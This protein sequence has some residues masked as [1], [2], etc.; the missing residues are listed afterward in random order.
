[1]SRRDNETSRPY[2]SLGYLRGL[3]DYL[4]SRN[5]P[6]EPV[7][8]AMNLSSEAQL[9][10]PNTRVDHA[11]LDTIFEAAERL[12]GDANVGLH[13]G[14][15][16]N[17]LHFG[18]LGQLAVTCRNMRELLKL[19]T[20]Y[21]RLIT[22][23]A[24]MFYEVSPDK[25]VG[26]MMYQ[27]SAPVS[28]HS[29]EYAFVSHVKLVRLLVGDK[30]KP[31]NVEVPYRAPA[32]SSEQE[33]FF[34]CSI[35]YKREKERLFFP[36][37]LLD[38]PLVIHDSVSR[39][40]LEIEARRRLDALRIAMAEEV[41]GYP[42]VVGI[43]RFM[44]QQLKGGEPPSVDTTAEALNVSVRTL[45]RRLEV[46]G[47]NFRELIDLV[48]RDLA[49]EYMRDAALSPVDIAFLLGYSEQS[50]FFRAFRR[51]FDMTPREYRSLRPPR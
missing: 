39:E 12:T 35:S 51:W 5:A 13:A 17:I 37:S 42:R 20:R 34:G 48:R 30:L 14:E 15:S 50:A 44:S 28:R 2:I 3:L 21:Q 46:V 40:T 24:R 22:N 6:V 36:P 10:D 16:I 49:D 43:K 33:R 45:Q 7:L 32:D 26:E 41:D 11:L 25:I 29:L 18:M 4:R 31:I 9:R 38:V 23:G 1:M 27:K 8:S 19:R 47:I